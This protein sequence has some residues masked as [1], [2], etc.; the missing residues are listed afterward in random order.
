MEQARGTPVLVQSLKQQASTPLY[1]LSM[2]DIRINS[3]RMLVKD[4]LVLI[5]NKTGRPFTCDAFSA[6]SGVNSIV[7]LSVPLLNLS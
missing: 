4:I 3:D 7:L 5:E 6:D 1:T 2:S